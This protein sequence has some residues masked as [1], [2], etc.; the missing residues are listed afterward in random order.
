MLRATAMIM[1]LSRLEYRSA[2]VSS[3]LF[4]L[5]SPLSP[6]AP[7]PS[8]ALVPFIS[9]ACVDGRTWYSADGV[10]FASF[11]SYASRSFSAVICPKTHRRQQ[12]QHQ[13][14]GAAATKI[15]PTTAATAAAEEHSESLS[16]FP[17][18]STVQLCH[19]RTPCLSRLHPALP[20][21]L[22]LCGAQQITRSDLGERDE[23]DDATLPNPPAWP[24]GLGDGARRRWP[25]L[26]ALPLGL[27]DHLHPGTQTLAQQRTENTQADL[28]IWS[29]GGIGQG[30]PSLWDV[31]TAAQDAR[32]GPPSRKRDDNAMQVD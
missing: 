11:L 20:P 5:P 9:R 10:Y 8:L 25:H 26:A 32:R 29:S 3:P 1:D 13:Q 21:A 23:R 7:F 2:R 30:G 19:G 28:L 14:T 31:S 12:R 24:H 4:N 22:C 18:V 15:S 16:S 27:L 6:L 17:S